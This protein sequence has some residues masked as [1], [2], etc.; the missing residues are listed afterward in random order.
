[1]NFIPSYWIWIVLAIFLA[2]WYLFGHSQN[3]HTGPSRANRGLS[4]SHGQNQKHMED[5]ATEDPPMQE[6]G[7]R[8]HGGCC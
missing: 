5:A 2:G 7:H 1:M 8:H 3:E 6:R 4:S